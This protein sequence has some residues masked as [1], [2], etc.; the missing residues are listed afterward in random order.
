MSQKKAIDNWKR[1]E[2]LLIKNRKKQH[3][4][5]RDRE[6]LSRCYHLR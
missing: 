3:Q 6:L 1:T 4:S 5:Q 2:Y